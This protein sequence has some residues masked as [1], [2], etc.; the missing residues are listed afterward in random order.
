MFLTRTCMKSS[1]LFSFE[2]LIFDIKVYMCSRK[3]IMGFF[4]KKSDFKRYALVDRLLHNG[5]NFRAVS[6][7]PTA[8][9]I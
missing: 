1:F 9:D 8:P 6:D 3:N 2:P 7:F 5:C 4:F